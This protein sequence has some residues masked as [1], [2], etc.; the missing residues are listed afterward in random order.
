M[1]NLMNLWS[2][3]LFLGVSF[4]A[5]ADSAA[6][7]VTVQDFIKQYQ[8]TYKVDMINGQQ[9]K[10]DN[11][12]GSV[13]MENNQGILSFS[14]CQPTGVCDPGRNLLPADK[15]VI[16]QNRVSNTDSVYDIVATLTTKTVHYTW[17]DKD[18][19]ITLKHFD[20]KLTDGTLITLVHDTHKTGN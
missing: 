15:T 11:E 2:V 12:N 19:K 5:L 16:T 4:A 13:N 3:V 18:G 20:Y 10:P 17:E 9:A 1:K 7:N 14:F 6:Q 8:G